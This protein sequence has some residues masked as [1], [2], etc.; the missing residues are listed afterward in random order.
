MAAAD[1]IY[2]I[3]PSSHIS[4]TGKVMWSAFSANSKGRIPTAHIAD[5]F[6]QYLSTH[7]KQLHSSLTITYYVLLQ[8]STTPELLP[9]G[10]KI[11]LQ[12]N[13]QLPFSYHAGSNPE[14][15][16]LQNVIPLM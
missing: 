7:A 16:H 10:K 12:N 4:S 15:V 1:C 2:P 3:I 6:L 8:T 11:L 14:Q 9:V 5:F 13:F